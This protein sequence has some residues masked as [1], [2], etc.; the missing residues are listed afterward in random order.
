MREEEKF[1]R[2]FEL[3][4]KWH[5]FPWPL[6]GDPVDILWK[7]GLIEIEAFRELA[8]LQ[9]DVHIQQLKGRLE[10]AEKVQEMLK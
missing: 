7:D 8:R 5:G 4:K 1:S 2:A 10:I 6:D 9:L 3:E